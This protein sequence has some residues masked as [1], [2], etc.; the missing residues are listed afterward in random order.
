VRDETDI[1]HHLQNLL[2]SAKY[3]VTQQDDNPAA[4]L[5]VRTTGAR[6][7][8]RSTPGAEKGSCVQGHTSGR[9]VRHRLAEM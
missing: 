3:V 2:L 5:P 4:K 9:Q 6:V 7:R 8:P 1:R